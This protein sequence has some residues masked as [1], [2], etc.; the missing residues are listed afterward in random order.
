MV[1]SLPFYWF[2]DRGIPRG[3]ES[4]DTGPLSAAAVAAAAVAPYRIT[5]MV[6]LPPPPPPCGDPDRRVQGHSPRAE[7]RR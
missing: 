5:S 7:K 2:P 3:P 4:R 1:G 6:P